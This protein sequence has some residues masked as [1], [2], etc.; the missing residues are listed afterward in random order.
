[1][2]TP[3]APPPDAALPCQPGQTKA[4]TAS[5]LYYAPTSRQYAAVKDNITCFDTAAQAATAGY[6]SA[7]P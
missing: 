5:K 7:Q 3:S 2:G 6:Q 4:D 1:V